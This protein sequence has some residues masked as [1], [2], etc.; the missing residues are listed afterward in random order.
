MLATFRDNT[1]TN[2]PLCSRLTLEWNFLIDNVELRAQQVF[3]RIIRRRL[4]LAFSTTKRNRLRKLTEADMQETEVT[5][6]RLLEKDCIDN[7]IDQQS[8][9]DGAEYKVAID[10]QRS[11]VS[12]H[13]PTLPGVECN[14]ERADDHFLDHLSERLCQLVDIL[15]DSLIAKRYDRKVR[16]VCQCAM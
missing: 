14:R 5:L 7:R 1:Q 4:G 8:T 2:R 9:S 12:R 16:Y 15:S 11:N 10:A 6:S 3:Q 13:L